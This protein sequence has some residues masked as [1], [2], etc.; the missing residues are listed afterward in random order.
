MSFR[1]LISTIS[2]VVSLMLFLPMAFAETSGTIN[3]STTNASITTGFF[4]YTVQYCNSDADCYGYKC[5]VDYDGVS[6][7]SYSGWCNSTS[8]TT[9]Y[10][11]ES[12]T[13]MVTTASGSSYCVSTSAYRTCTS[14]SW[15][16]QASCL[17]GYTCSSGSCVQTNATNNTP[18]GTPPGGTP[19]GNVTT[20]SIRITATIGNFDIVQGES[21]T[22]QLTV[23]N[24]GQRTLYTVKIIIKGIN[25]SWYTIS[26]SSV[27]TL[28]I[29]QIS[30]FTVT[31]SIPKNAEVN[32]YTIT[33][34]ANSSLAVASATFSLRVLPSNETV[35][36]DIIPKYSNITYTYKGLE[37]EIAELEKSKGNVTELKNLLANLK[38]KIDQANKSIE[39]KNYFDANNLLAEAEQIIADIKAKM[40]EKKPAKPEETNL[41][42][43]SIIAFIIVMAIFFVYLFWPTGEKRILKKIESSRKEEKTNF[44]GVFDRIRKRKQYHYQPTGKTDSRR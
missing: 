6:S 31:F 3:F 30:T 8:I 34:E 37:N 17:S 32:A 5:F 43:I 19:G 7:G 2:I 24:N 23:K 12:S 44:K 4:G 26:P 16:S 29:D 1:L 20:P 14:G 42:L 9:C 22:K 35:T 21:A 25:G 41:F 10:H 38:N 40:A 15:G 11:D 27:S 28:N 18:P 33:T 36:S 39:S 13:G